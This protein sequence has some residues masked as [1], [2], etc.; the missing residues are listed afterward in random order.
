MML[1]I[2]CLIKNCLLHITQEK[3]GSENCGGGGNL[4]GDNCGVCGNVDVVLS[5]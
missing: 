2:V 1:M 4:V 5:V 3:W